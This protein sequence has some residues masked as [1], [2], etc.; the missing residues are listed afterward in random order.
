MYPMEKFPGHEQMRGHF[1]FNGHND[2]V[3]FRNIRI[4]RLDAKPSGE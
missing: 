1:G 4:K 3:Q 2:P